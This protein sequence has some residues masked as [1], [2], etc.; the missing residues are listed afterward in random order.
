MKATKKLAALALALLMVLSVGSAFAD[1]ANFNHFINE[2]L[3][4]FNAFDL[5]RQSL[6]VTQNGDSPFTFLIQENGGVF[7]LYVSANDGRD[8]INVQVTKD[9]ATLYYNGRAF[10]VNMSDV[11]G[12]L[13]DTG[14]ITGMA[15][16]M[17]HISLGSMGSIISGVTPDEKV[18]NAVA[19]AL[20]DLVQSVV[21]S[22]ISATADEN[23]YRLVISLTGAQFRDLLIAWLDKAV[24]RKDWIDPL[25]QYANQLYAAYTDAA[26]REAAANG[27]SYSVGPSGIPGSQEELAQKWTTGYRDEVA[28]ALMRNMRGNGE[29]FSLSFLM[30]KAGEIDE[31]RFTQA[32]HPRFRA[33]FEDDFLRISNGTGNYHTSMKADSDNEITV[34]DSQ[35][36]ELGHIR[37]QKIGTDWTLTVSAPAYSYRSGEY[38]Q[39][40][41]ITF[42]APKTP[43]AIENPTVLTREDLIRLLNQATN[44]R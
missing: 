29:I 38:T 39:E 24:T 9:T 23:G 2:T 11:Y 27:W 12:L 13:E 15:G 22:A 43:K 21:N 6:T 42:G 17:A 26:A 31:I 16:S 18:I 40:V 8:E 3:N 34:F 30:N 33:W 14:T 36:N 25:L 41:S 44:Y 35:D 28:R 5:S 19:A 7:W 37:Q 1:R 20:T 10:R 4:Q 32:G